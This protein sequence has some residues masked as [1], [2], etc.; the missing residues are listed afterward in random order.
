MYSSTISVF[1]A[2]LGRIFEPNKNVTGIMTLSAIQVLG[3][4]FMIIIFTLG[5]YNKKK[6]LSSLK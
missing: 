5:F 1:I 2:K 6:I 3:L 4:L